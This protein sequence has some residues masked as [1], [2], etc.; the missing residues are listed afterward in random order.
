MPTKQSR[1]I[2]DTNLWISF[3]I[4]KN[5][6]HLDKLILTNNCV[7]LFSKELLNEFIE[8]SGRPKFK[9]Y[10]SKED[11]KLLLDTIV[12]CV[13]FIDVTTQSVGCKDVKDNFLLALSV[14]GRADYLITGD[15][16]LLSIGKYGKTKILTITNFMQEHNF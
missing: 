10:F 4:T 15:N 2:L 11:I 5:Y 8:V 16:D 3:L 6:N 7:L 1:I 9:K 14:D 13:D 12:Q